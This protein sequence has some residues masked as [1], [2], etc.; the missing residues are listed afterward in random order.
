MIEQNG[1][2]AALQ[3]ENAALRQRITEL[4]RLHFKPAADTELHLR[5]DAPSA[6]SNPDWTVI[7]DATDEAIIVLGADGTCLALNELAAQRAGLRREELVGARVVD[8]V[9]AEIVARWQP[10]FE[11]LVSSGE[12]SI[13]EVQQQARWLLNRV[14]PV[15]DTHGQVARLVIYSRDITD[16]KQREAQLR[17]SEERLREVLEN[18]LDAAYKRNFTTNTYDYLSPV[19]AQI[20]GY[21]PEEFQTLPL[22][23]VLSLIHADDHA[24]I[25]RVINASLA[26]PAGVPYQIDYRFKHQSGQYIWLRDRFIVLRDAAGRPVARVGSVS[27]ITEQRQTE[28]ALRTSEAR[29]RTLLEN[30]PAFVAEA[31]PAGLILALNRTQPGFTQKDYVGRSLFDVVAPESREQFKAAFA[32]TL[33]E[34]RV[35]E[36]EAPG[37]GPNRAPAWYYR[38]LVPIKSG[39]EISSILMVASDTTARRLAEE[40]LRASE[41]KWRGVFDFL[42]VGVSIVDH[43]NHVVEANS[44]LSRILR[45]SESGMQA[46]EYRHR[47]YFRADGSPMSPEEFPSLRAIVEQRVIHNVEIGI[48]T[49]TGDL[50]WTNVSATPLPDAAVT[51]TVTVD[52]TERKQSEAALRESEARFRSYFELPLTG[53]AITAPDATWL[54]VNSVLCDMLDYTKAELLHKTWLELTHPDDVAANQVQLSRVLTDEIDGF[55]LEKRFIRRDGQI[56]HAELVVQCLRHPDRSVNYFVVLVFDI[57]ARKRTEAAEREARQL[58]EALRDTAIALNSSLELDAVLDQ[59]LMAVG[60]VVPNDGASIWLIEQDQ[61]RLVR[62]YGRFS[63]TALQGETHP[64]DSLYRLRIMRDTGQPCIIDHT[65]DDLNWQAW[66][67]NEWIQ[68]YAGVPIYARGELAGFLGL[69]S[70]EPGHFSALQGERLKMFAHQA[71]LAVQNAQLHAQLR[72]H[73]DELEARVAE[74]TRQLAERNQQLLE[75]DQLKDQFVSRISHEL[76]TPLSNIKIYLELL[77]FGKPDKR[78]IYMQTLKEQTDRLQQLIESLLAVTQQSVNAAGLH[79]LPI[80]LNQ[81]AASLAAD[82]VS[83]AQAHGLTLTTTLAPDLPL[84]LAD[85]VLLTQ[86]LSN[87]TTN[88]L[89]YTPAGGTIE[90]STAEIVEQDQTWVTF[91][92]RDSGPGLAPEDQPHI[93]ERFYR[94]R[95]AANYTIPGAGLGLSISR[96]I[97]TQLEGRLTAESDGVLGHGSAFTAWLR[98]A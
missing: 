38:Q 62:G 34:R 63:T 36:Y 92:V 12:S 49:E 17:A 23:V 46:G 44:A 78:A 75:L 26:G 98:P 1:E 67:G 81:L 39:T 16:R 14:Y 56:I 32:Q 89:S 21:T 84:A 93:F 55:T 24:E 20:S 27:D 31:D 41:A 7:F 57:T 8:R 11:Q 79:L 91:T 71:A 96:A 72:E 88:A 61:A 43:H 97:L 66:P 54:E 15:K 19:F 25:D 40:D 5:S 68:S 33:A 60:Q 87:L 85:T 42:P 30:L 50:I 64:I 65:H 45:L 35:V 6:I 4:E 77:D 9:P 37:F 80:D 28:E 10:H 2:L 90:I 83:R 86:A 73:A 74:R 48:E 76:R 47:R 58:A 95:A 13:F 52:I 94:G 29:W 22:D 53:R 18:S 59:V 82:T 3:A 69:Y 70:A 51:V